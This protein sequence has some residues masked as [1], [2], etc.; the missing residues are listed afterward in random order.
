MIWSAIQF[1]FIRTCGPFLMGGRP[2]GEMYH[3][4]DGARISALAA[5]CIRQCKGNFYQIYLKL[6]YIH[7][8]HSSLYF[9][10]IPHILM[11]IIIIDHLCKPPTLLIIICTIGCRYLSIIVYFIN[12]DRRFLVVWPW[13]FTYLTIGR[14]GIVHVPLYPGRC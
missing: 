12:I 6:R 5:S 7:F 13:P 1:I 11:C 10:H 3:V 8:V 4:R 2:R 9:V 14:W